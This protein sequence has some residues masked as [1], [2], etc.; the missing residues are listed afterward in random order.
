MQSNARKGVAGGPPSTGRRRTRKFVMPFRR[1]SLSR[2]TG[3]P[4][5]QPSSVSLEPGNLLCKWNTVCRCNYYPLPPLDP[6]FYCS[7][8]LSIRIPRLFVKNLCK[9]IGVMSI[10]NKWTS[11]MTINCVGGSHRSRNVLGI[12]SPVLFIIISIPITMR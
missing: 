9:L 7:T 1:R 5:S 12:E 4:F 8:R 3:N 11:L 10:N 2:W 6:P